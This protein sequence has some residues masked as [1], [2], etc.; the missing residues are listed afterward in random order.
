MRVISILSVAAL[1]PFWPGCIGPSPDAAHTG[2][3]R[4]HLSIDRE[5][6]ARLAEFLRSVGTEA[7][8]PQPMLDGKTPIQ[9]AVKGAETAATGD[10]IGGAI[11]AGLA[12]MATL[13]AAMGWSGSRTAKRVEGRMSGG[14]HAR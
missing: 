11:Q 4:D 3:V 8:S 13:G 1:L 12:V 2:A 9:V 14:R 10:R 5:T 7:R 6:A